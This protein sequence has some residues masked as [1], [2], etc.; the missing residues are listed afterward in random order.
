LGDARRSSGGA[1]AVLHEG[2]VFAQDPVL[3]LI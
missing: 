3:A 1:A 2:V